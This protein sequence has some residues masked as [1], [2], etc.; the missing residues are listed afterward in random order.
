MN[1]D[2]LSKMPV[3][4]PLTTRRTG[5]PHTSSTCTTYKPVMNSATPDSPMSKSAYTTTRARPL[6]HVT[7]RCTTVRQKEVGRRIPCTLCPFN[8]VPCTRS[9]FPRSRSQTWLKIGRTE[10]STI[11]VPEHGDPRPT[12]NHQLSSRLH[13]FRR[14]ISARN[15]RNFNLNEH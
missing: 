15:Q 11:I 9:L 12:Q 2:H 8:F 5:I 1:I 7:G 13:K 4:L 6:C 10:Y 3:L 14:I